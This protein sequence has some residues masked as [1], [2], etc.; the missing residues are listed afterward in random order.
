MRFAK[1]NYFAADLHAYTIELPRSNIAVATTAMEPACFAECW[2]RQRNVLMQHI[3]SLD[4]KAGPQIQEVLAH[5][6]THYQ[7]Y[8][9]CASFGEWQKYANAIAAVPR[10][11]GGRLL[12]VVNCGGQGLNLLPQ[13]LMTKVWPQLVALVSK[14]QNASGEEV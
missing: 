10:S 2:D 6:V 12:M 3:R 5:A 1:V 14:L 13:F 4:E 11:I 9:C 7:E 8:G